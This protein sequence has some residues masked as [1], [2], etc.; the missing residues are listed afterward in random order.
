MSSKTADTF[1]AENTIHIRVRYA[2]C[3]PMGLAHHGSYPI[4]L[5]MAR[6]ELLREQGGVYRQLEEQ[7]IFFVVARM[8][9]RYQR[10]IRYDD[11]IDVRVRLEPSAGVKLVHSYE[12]TRDGE[13]LAKAQ[14]TLACVDRDGKLRPVPEALLG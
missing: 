3:D 13:K 9:L 5:E 10:P 7:G 8:S 4:W 12:I 6:T 14:T 1:V 11:E 2:E